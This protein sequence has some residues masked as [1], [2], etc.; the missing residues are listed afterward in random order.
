MPPNPSGLHST[1]RIAER[2]SI[3]SATGIAPTLNSERN[4]FYAKQDAASVRSGLGHTRADSTTGSIGGLNNPL[5]SP[6]EANVV[7]R[8]EGQEE[9][10]GAKPKGKGKAVAKE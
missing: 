9:D 5:A 4:S 2:T 10:R 7:E 6:R 8:D 1:A 3:Y